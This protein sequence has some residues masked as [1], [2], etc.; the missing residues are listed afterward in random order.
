ML[1]PGVFSSTTEFTWVNADS[2]GVTLS[3]GQPGSNMDSLWIYTPVDL[4]SSN[5]G[6]VNCAN[7]TASGIKTINL[8]LKGNTTVGTDGDSNT[9]SVFGGGEESEVTGDISITL[10]GSTHVKG[11]VFGGGNEGAVTGNTEV[12]IK[13]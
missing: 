1:E 3:N 2:A 4:R 10:Q 13:D 9:G 11:D 8:T 7:C 12:I 5:L 6:S